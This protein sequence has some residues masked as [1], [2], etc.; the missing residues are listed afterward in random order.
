LP[1]IKTIVACEFNSHGLLFLESFLNVL[2]PPLTRKGCSLNGR[3]KGV[4]GCIRNPK[5]D[6]GGVVET[7][8][9][10]VDSDGTVTVD[11]S[12]TGGLELL[13]GWLARIASSSSSN[14][15][16]PKVN[17]NKWHQLG[18]HAQPSVLEFQDIHTSPQDGQ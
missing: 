14:T 3:P 17:R 15:C 6:G 1:L 7:E 5:T 16:V 10:V 13:D 11:F 18:P 8:A 4:S 9:L 12:T 2:A